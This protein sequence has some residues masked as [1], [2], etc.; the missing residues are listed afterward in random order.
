MNRREFLINTAYKIGGISL[1]LKMGIPLKKAF[2]AGD[3]PVLFFSDLIDGPYNGW[4]GSSTKGAAITIWGLNFGSSGS[5]TCAGQEIQYNDS[6]YMAEWGST[7]NNAR[8]LESITFWLKNT[9]STGA[10]K[11]KVTVG[12]VDS[13]ELDFYVRTTGN[14]YFVSTADGNNSYDGTYSTYQS[15]TI[16]PWATLTGRTGIS[17]GDIIYLRAGSYTDST[18]VDSAIYT[19][20]AAESGSANN[21][22]A[23]I[24]YPTEFPT[25]DARTEDSGRI[26]RDEY[27]ENAHHFVISRL[28]LIPDN[29]GGTAV[30]IG[31]STDENFR[32][33]GLDVDGLDGYTSH[34]YAGVVNIQ[35]IGNFKVYGCQVRRFGYDQYDHAIYVGCNTNNSSKDTVNIDLGWNEIYDTATYVSGIYVHPVDSG[36]G[37]ADEVYIHDNYIHG[38]SHAGIYLSSRWHDVYVYNNIIYNCGGAVYGTV[39]LCT[40]QSES[41]NCRFFHN[42]V[43]ADSVSQ[44]AGLI[45]WDNTIHRSENVTMLNNILYSLNSTPYNY[46]G[47][48]DGTRSSDYDIWYGNGS[49]PAWAGGNC[50]NSNPLF[51]SPGTGDFSLQEGSPADDAGSEA[52]AVITLVTKDYYGKTRSNTNRDIG[53]IMYGAG[54]SS[55]VSIPTV[56]GIVGRPGVTLK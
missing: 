33:I 31:Y 4:E 48:F 53:A 35:N 32:V 42:T 17:S 50:V 54:G 14:I 15:G 47:S 7:S 41:S 9:M 56:Y 8:G 29:A 25:L 11:I 36:T 18:D 45:R 16:G 40:D 30:D 38:M 19:M 39:F 1:L 22:T 52:S 27:D 3:A 21:M 2:A 37:I 10:Q 13:N 6:T 34:I 5:V 51:V 49:V 24:G 26:I 55:P 28:K 12:G 20:V 46:D 23:L 44:G 43:Y